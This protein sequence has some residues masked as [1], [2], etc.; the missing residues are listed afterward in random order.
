MRDTSDDDAAG[1]ITLSAGMTCAVTDDPDQLLPKAYFDQWAGGVAI[2]S[3]RLGAT[4]RLWHQ[5]VRGIWLAYDLDSYAGAA[6]H[7]AELTPVLPGMSLQ[8]GISEDEVA[9]LRA[10]LGRRW[11]V[12]AVG[13]T[14]AVYGDCPVDAGLDNQ[15]L[16][17]VKAAL[18]RMAWLG[19]LRVVDGDPRHYVANLAPA[20]VALRAATGRDHCAR[21]HVVASEGAPCAACAAKGSR[22]GP[23]GP[24]PVPILPILD[25]SWVTD[26]DRRIVLVLHRTVLPARVYEV[27]HCMAG[28]DPG[29]VC[30]ADRHS[31]M[32][33]GVGRRLAM[34]AAAGIAE[35][36]SDGRYILGEAARRRVDDVL[37]QASGEDRRDTSA[38]PAGRPGRVIELD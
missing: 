31:G 19:L 8:A 36:L 30:R 15:R 3:R 25:A 9:V 27:A 7:E 20:L 14:I 1:V 38:P 10:V 2:G 32:V 29:E 28:G 21:G 18:D 23:A 34:L 11:S 5:V 17:G 6:Y 37:K 16:A 24:A 35:R 12:S 13:V 22:P 4:V 33:K 26:N